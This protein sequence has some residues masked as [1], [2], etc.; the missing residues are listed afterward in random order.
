MALICLPGS[1]P[2][3]TGGSGQGEESPGD[4]L[5]VGSWVPSP[6]TFQQ[7]CTNALHINS[8]E[9]SW[10]GRLAETILAPS[11]SKGVQKCGENLG[12]VLRVE[13][14]HSCRYDHM[15]RRGPPGVGIREAKGLPNRAGLSLPMGAPTPFRVC[16]CAAHEVLRPP[17]RSCLLMRG[18]L[19]LLVLTGPLHLL[20][21]LFKFRLCCSHGLSVLLPLFRRQVPQLRLLF[22]DLGS[23][24]PRLGHLP[25]VLSGLQAQ[26]ELLRLM[27][28]GVDQLPDAEGNP[29]QAGGAEAAGT[30]E[31]GEALLHGGT[32]LVDPAGA[33]LL[34]LLLCLQVPCPVDGGTSRLL[35]VG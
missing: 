20:T 6:A 35:G 8:G 21:C 34:G 27:E 5:G 11:R 16:V 19:P 3:N 25:A 33:V 9:M 22:G 4:R 26:L 15:G 28:R 14:L 23:L 24:Q 29:G 31:A 2:T 18:R 13:I 32:V 30:T 7:D 12:A 17:L 10:R 1:S